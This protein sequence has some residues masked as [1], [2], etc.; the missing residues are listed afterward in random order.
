[1]INEMNRG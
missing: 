1:M